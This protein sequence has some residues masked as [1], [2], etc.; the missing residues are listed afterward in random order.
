MMVASKWIGFDKIKHVKRHFTEFL[1]WGVAPTNTPEEKAAKR[2]FLLAVT[3]GGLVMAVFGLLC[4]LQEKVEIGGLLLGWAGWHGVLLFSLRR[5]RQ[6]EPLL[7]M[8]T[9]ILFVV[10]WAIGGLVEYGLQTSLLVYALSGPALIQALMPRATKQVMVFYAVLV[11]ASL[12]RTYWFEFAPSSPTWLSLTWIGTNLLLTG[13]VISLAS[14]YFAAQI[15][16]INIKLKQEQDK[17]ERLLTS[18]FPAKVAAQVKHSLLEE[19]TVPAV[20]EQFHEASVLFADMV[21]FTALTSRLSAREL[22][23]LLNT[24]FSQFDRLAEKYGLEKI[25]T[26]GDCYIVAAGLPNPRPDHARALA[27]LA[28]EIQSVVKNYRLTE[29]KVSFRVGIH[30]GPVVAGVIGQKKI[31]YD[32]WGDTV[33][34]ASRMASNAPGGGIQITCQTRNALGDE[35]I[36]VP[37]GQVFVKGKGEMEAWLLTGKANPS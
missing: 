30:T 31:S 19:S 26:V 29:H 16:R 37:R 11:L 5:V 15:N 33:N 14:L 27:E 6:V 35:Y 22:V 32:L 20:A 13:W 12:A 7:V 23:S 24:I 36:C 9:A 17:I 21:G 4:F 10:V 28:L 3:P 8:H 25:K 34:I 2:L 18:I 1:S